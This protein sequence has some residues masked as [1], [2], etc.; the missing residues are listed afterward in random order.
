MLLYP[1]PMAQITIVSHYAKHKCLYNFVGVN[2]FI[3]QPLPI[4]QNLL[5]MVEL[6]CP[7]NDQ[8]RFQQPSCILKVGI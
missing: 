3:V 4:R 2:Y 1:T 8:K 7:L 5:N 6:T